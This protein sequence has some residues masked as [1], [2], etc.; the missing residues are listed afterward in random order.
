MSQ[1]FVELNN[2]GPIP[3]VLQG[4]NAT[5]RGPEGLDI[6]WLVFPDI[7]LDANSANLQDVISTLTI[8]NQDKCD[9][10]LPNFKPHECPITT[11]GID[12]LA[13]R[14]VTWTVK[15]DTVLTALGFGSEAP[16]RRTMRTTQ[17]YSRPPLRCRL[18]RP[19]RQAA[20]LPRSLAGEL[21]HEEC[22]G[23]TLGGGGGGLAIRGLVSRGPF[24]ISFS[25]RRPAP[26]QMS[27]AEYNPDFGEDPE[28]KPNSIVMTADIE[29]SS[30]S[31]LEFR[32][33]GTMRADLFYNLD[34][35]NAEKHG[36]RCHPP[37]A[38]HASRAEGVR[39]GPWPRP[40]VC[41]PFHRHE[42]TNLM[43]DSV[44]LFAPAGW[45]SE[46]GLVYGSRLCTEQMLANDE[47]RSSDDEA[48]FDPHAF[49]TPECCL[50]SHLPSGLDSHRILR[51]V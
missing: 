51:H 20:D 36:A 40:C 42:P 33:I 46:Y 7:K 29:F 3:A 25:C 4:F 14:S 38:P 23:G 47:C 35:N 48:S 30:V 1:A 50:T 21:P 45:S 2:A 18:P 11:E 13:G 34:A 41:R 8:L 6:G 10:T 37:H 12:L 28:M 43:D 24:R 32:K 19:H 16:P 39:G 15:G 26:L 31:V 49:Q 22:A 9:T 44:Y 17:T 5:L 27:N